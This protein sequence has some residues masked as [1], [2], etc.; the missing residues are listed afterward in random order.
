MQGEPVAQMRG[1]RS[2]ASAHT[3]KVV[4]ATVMGVMGKGTGH[5]EAEIRRVCMVMGVQM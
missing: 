1:A 3:M 2:S 5:G 4:T